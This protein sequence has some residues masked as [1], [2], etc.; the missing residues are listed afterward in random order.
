MLTRRNSATWPGAGDAGW[1]GEAED[2]CWGAG[3]GRGGLGNGGLVILGRCQL[4]GGV[5]ACRR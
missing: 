1:G 5:A 2:V 4:G 3:A